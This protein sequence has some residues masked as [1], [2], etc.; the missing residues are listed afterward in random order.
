M[1]RA[2]RICV[3]VLGIAQRLT[4]PAGCCLPEYFM[5]QPRGD[6]NNNGVQTENWGAH[7]R[8]DFRVISEPGRKINSR[9]PVCSLRA[10]THKRL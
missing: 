10:H 8:G 6:N 3:T 5:R 7:G 2:K 9:L 4:R 1:H